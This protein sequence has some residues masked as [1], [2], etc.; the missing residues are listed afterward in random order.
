MGEFDEAAALTVRDVRIRFGGVTALDGV[1]LTVEPGRICG[2]IG[3]NGAGKTTLFNCVTRIY[4]PN[5]GTIRFGDTDLLTLRRHQVVRHGIARTFQNLALFPSLSILANTMVGAHTRNRAHFATAAVGWPT[6][7]RNQRRLEG[8]ALDILAA[9]DLRD[10]AHR[11][12]QGLPFGT[13]KRVELARALAARPRL[14]LLDEPAGGLTHAEVHDLG[15]L[16]RRVSRE[17][18]LSALLV[19]HHMGLVMGICDHVVAMDSGRTI[20]AGTP[21]EVQQDP[22]V[23]AAYLGRAANK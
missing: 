23:V 5:S 2:L 15:E 19:E 17:Y 10:V 7:R 13:L 21:A 4:Q 22:A 12:A 6:T 16:I 18:R 14:L 20:A 9:L 11:P 3:P 1:S 8:E